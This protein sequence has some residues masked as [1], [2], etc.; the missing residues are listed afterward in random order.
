MFLETLFGQSKIA[1]LHGTLS[2][3]TT[4]TMLFNPHSLMSTFHS[5]GIDLSKDKKKLSTERVRKHREMFK[6]TN[7]SW[8]KDVYAYV[9]RKADKHQLKFSPFIVHAVMGYLNL[10][11]ILPDPDV[12][13]QLQLELR[14]QGCNL[15]QIAYNCNRTRNVSENAIKEALNHVK[16][17][18]NLVTKALTYPDD[19]ESLVKQALKERPSF[20]ITLQN[21]LDKHYKNAH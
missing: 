16:R 3:T 9:K 13:Y 6:C 8:E 15:N 14:R 21:V 20:A 2:E 18:E 17:I 12:L 11:F 7:I 4:E 19:L 1:L 5:F 10:M